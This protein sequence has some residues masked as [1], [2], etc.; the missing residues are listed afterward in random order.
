MANGPARSLR[1]LVAEVESRA[2][3]LIINANELVE[4]LAPEVTCSSITQDSR[5]VQP[6]AVFCAIRGHSVDGHDF[7]DG[8]IASGAVAIVIDAARSATANTGNV[9]TILTGD[10][11][12]ATGFLSAALWDQPTNNMALVAVTG[13]NGKTSVVTIL[14]H[15]VNACGG[16]AASMGTLTGSL[17]TAAAPDFHAALAEHRTNGATVVA[18]EVSSHALDQQRIAGAV[19]AVAVF[20]NLSQDHLDYHADMEDYFLAKARL[21]GPDYNAPSVID[22]SGDYGARLADMT[23]QRSSAAEMVRVEGNAIA[24]AGTLHEGSSTFTWRDRRIDLP[25]GGAF[26]VNNAVMAAE[27]AVLL[28]HT[29]DDVAAALRTVPAVPGRFESVDAG[30]PF[31]VI[32]DYSHTPASVAAAV[33]SARQ[34]SDGKIIL[35]FGAAGDR[36][37]GKRPLMGQAA[38]AADRL[39]VTSDN[40]RTEDPAKIIDEVVAGITQHDDVHVFVDRSDAISKAISGAT[41]G[42]IVVIAGKGHEDYQI[43]GTTRTH[44]DDRVEARRSLAAAGWETNS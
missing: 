35:V 42:D 26:S 24:H 32:V 22:V 17:T 7:L 34:L 36:D 25:L 23:A 19:V 3:G 41:A 4:S 14:A 21:F 9:I 1:D 18:A 33:D 29:L 43:V 11:A 6:D 15:I 12:K 40:P 5:D 37:P 2:P 31:A 38:A 44:F 13:T 20:T 16:Q 27:A 39:Y 28:G 30:Q 10:T 8:A